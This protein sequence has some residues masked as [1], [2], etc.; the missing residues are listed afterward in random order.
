VVELRRRRRLPERLGRRRP[1]RAAR[2]LDV[3]AKPDA[4]G[5]SDAWQRAGDEDLYSPASLHCIEASR[6][7]GPSCGHS[8]CQESRAD[9]ALA[10]LGSCALLGS[11]PGER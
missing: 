6:R 3:F 10:L 4:P 2:F 8:H 9:R 7:N 5:P 1:D 11:A